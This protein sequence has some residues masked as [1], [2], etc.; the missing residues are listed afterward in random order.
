MAIVF[1][2]GI[3]IVADPVAGADRVGYID[4]NRLVRESQMGKKAQA[5][6]AALRQRKEQEIENKGRALNALREE[7]NTRGDRI[8]EEEKRQKVELLQRLYKEYQRLAADAK[9]DIVQQDR[10]LVARILKEADGILKAVA[11]KKNFAI[12]LKDP[13]AIG[14]LDPQVDITG[15]VLKALDKK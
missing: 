1:T 11:E 9:E 6:L 4:L 13:N 15:D 8:P 2:L 3:L 10:Q 14:Y 12:I 7:L 5:E